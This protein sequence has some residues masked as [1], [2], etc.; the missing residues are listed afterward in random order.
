M[1]FLTDTRQDLGF[2]ESD[3]ARLVGLRPLLE[4]H[5]GA[6]IDAHYKEL[7]T[8]EGTAAVLAAQEDGIV[9]RLR[10]TFIVWLKS[11]FVGPWDEAY[12]E[13]RY[14]IGHMHVK[15]GL[16]QQYV[17]TSMHRLRRLLRELVREQGGDGDDERAVDRLLDLELA[18]MLHSY[19]EER[20]R[21]QAERSYLERELRKRL[22]GPLIGVGKGVAWL[23]EQIDEAAQSDEPVTLTGEPGSGMES[24]AHGIH[25]GSSRAH[26]LFVHVNCAV[27]RSGSR[28]TLFG[29]AADN[30]PEGQGALVGQFDLARGGTLFLEGAHHLSSELQGK[31]LASLREADA[32]PTGGRVRVIATWPAGGTG[33]SSWRRVDD[34]L[35]QYLDAIRIRVPTLA[36]RREDIPLIA[37][38]FAREQAARL[39]KDFDS[40]DEASI[41]KLRSYPWPGNVTELESVIERAVIS[42]R[43][44]IVEVEDALLDDAVS[45]G[46]YK[47]VQ[48]IGAGGM[49]EVWRARHQLLARPAAVKI[50]KSDVIGTGEQA[51]MLTAR[52][53]R[54]AQ[55]TAQLASPHTVQLYDFGVA[56][57][58]SFFYVM[59]LLDGIDLERLVKERG[60]MSPARAVHFVRRI[61]LSLAEAHDLGLVHRDIKPANLFA[62][63]VG[64]EFD[65]PKVLDFGMVKTDPQ[66]G[67]TRL[68]SDGSFGGTPD[69]MPPELI[70]GEGEDVDGRADLYSLGCV[71]FYLLTGDVVFPSGNP[72]KVLMSHANQSPEAPSAR[73]GRSMPDGLD[74]VVLSCLAKDPADRPADALALY[75]ALSP[76]ADGQPWTRGDAAAWWSKAAKN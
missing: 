57:D 16:P 10:G 8:N 73:A 21:V 36:E 69:Y 30:W 14:R 29:G 37:E 47:L 76:V 24:V 23:R 48:K 54:E 43:D 39:G 58:G 55:S 44:G 42:S 4:P 64:R 71:A 49:G 20:E 59:E 74:D 66:G 9:E 38:H 50:I 5:Y 2:D 31:L 56:Q 70:M 52:F 3:E 6:V 11:A 40:I 12:Y 17:V 46:K 51:A 25:D 26:R 27:V 60:P 7:L 15:V 22:Q 18:I 65:F 75:D 61:C 67:E 72:M 28:T 13:Q 32:G 63:R 19:I 34:E 35:R 53:Q 68:T 62:A 45:V 33:T 41:G 1:T